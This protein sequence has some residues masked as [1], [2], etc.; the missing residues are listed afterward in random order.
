MTTSLRD[1]LAHAWNAFTGRENP[2]RGYVDYGYGYGRN[3]DRAMLTLGTERSIVGAIYN[4]IAV[5][6]MSINIRHVRVNQNGRFEE[7]IQSGLNE[8]LKVQANIDQSARAFINDVVLSMF[9]EGAIAIVPVECT[10]NPAVSTSYEIK[11]LRVGQI[12]EW[13]PEHVR[14]LVYNEKKGEKQEIVLPKSQVAIVENPFYTIMNEPNSDFRRVVHK[15]NLMDR[16]DE[17]IV[18]GKLDVLIQLPYTINSPVKQKRA[19]D[20][21]RDIEAQLTGSKYGIAYIDAVE[22]V[23]QLNRPVE[24]NFQPQVEYLRKQAFMQLGFSES[25]LDG[26]ADE[27]TKLN[28]FNSIVEPILTAI[29]DAMIRTFLTKT[30][31]SQGQ[32]IMYFRDP[33]K[34][35][36][37]EK[38]AEIADKMTRN[39]ILSS[40][41]I[42][43]IIGYK[44]D[45]DPRADELRNKNLNADNDQLSKT[46]K[47]QQV[48]QEQ[49]PKTKGGS[50]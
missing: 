15:Q 40:N 29:C 5:D 47:P 38:L 26:T 49:N 45:K 3:P 19:E 41:E 33:F 50:K 36:P 4:R 35:V 39:E 43:A 17:D 18:S 7:E 14:L 13:Y 6:V 20:R 11:S 10:L 48:M 22:R 27:Q 25:L 16:L 1:R 12:T 42:R 46:P 9:D 32:T 44:P 24:N 30:A 21:R 34:L 31:R 2:V 28:Y 8:C 23:T 37:V